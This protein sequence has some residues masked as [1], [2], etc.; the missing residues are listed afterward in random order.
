MSNPS[1]FTWIASA[2][3]LLAVHAA[4]MAAQQPVTLTLG[5]AAR[6]AAER[7]TGA[8]AAQYRVNMAEARLRQRRAD[9]LPTFAGALGFAQRTVNSAGFGLTFTDPTT[10]GDLFDPAGQVLGPIRTWDL[11]ATV[12]Q[13]VI[14]LSSF[15][16]I[17]AAGAAVAVADAD[18]ASAS[19]QAAGAAAMLYVRALR[20]DSRLSA[21]RADSTLAEELLRIARSQREAGMG[22]ALDVTRAEAQVAATRAQL[23]AARTER[24]RARLELQRALDLPLDASVELADSLLTM[25]TTF[26]APPEAGTIDRA[27]QTRTDLRM[28]QAQVDAAERQLGAIR[29]ERFPSLSIFADWGSTGGSTARMLQTYSWGVQ[30]SVPLFDGLRRRGRIA[31][32]RSAMREL[33]ARRRDLAQQVVLEAR[34]ALLELTSAVEQLR[35]ADERLLLA[36]QELDLA[37]RRFTEGVAG[38]AD[39]IT[40]LLALNA[41]RTEMVDT[42]A[43]FQSARVALAL[44]QGAVTELP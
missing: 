16:R 34:V 44:A 11:R 36:E 18:A 23:M 13:R 10:G 14:D 40:A 22:I 37:R 6:F 7:S 1:T 35:A 15:A 32:Q 5:D 38:N 17:R 29:A 9:L 28:I 25:P 4:S 21:R 19:Q 41:A 24:K 42:R 31:E 8:E 33:D 3:V 20:A 30:I 39:V 43:A 2:A 12:R 26:L 27:L